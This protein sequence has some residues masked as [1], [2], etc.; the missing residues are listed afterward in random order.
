MNGPCIWE[1]NMWAKPLCSD[2][3]SRQSAFGPTKQGENVP[4]KLPRKLVLTR[5]LSGGHLTAC[6]TG[7]KEA[8]W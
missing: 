8:I 7:L 5:E 2:S 1:K 4:G 6:C 3:F